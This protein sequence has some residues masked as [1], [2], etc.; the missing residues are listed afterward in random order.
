M[1]LKVLLCLSFAV[2]LSAIN[3]QKLHLNIEHAIKIALENNH[4]LKQIKLDKL[5]AAEQVRQTFGESVLP[6]VEGTATY[7]RAVKRP[8]FFIETP[9]FSGSVPSGTYNNLIAGIQ[10]DQ[11]I[12]TGAMFLAT[13]ISEGYNELAS[14]TEQYSEAELI[15][16]VKDSYYTYL[17]AKE[18][19]K[20][21]EL[22]I[23]RAEENLKNTKNMFSVGRVSEY[24]F[25][26][27]NVQYQNSIPVLS[28]AKNQLQLAANNFKILLGLDLKADME[29]SGELS[30]N[31]RE[32]IPAESGVSKLSNS[33]LLIKRSEGERKLQEL[34][35]SYQYSQHYPELRA[36]G[37]WQMQSQENDDRSFTNWR[38]INSISVGIN[39]RVPIFNGFSVDSRYQQ[40]KIDYDKSVEALSKTKKELM[41]EFENTLASIK[42]E[43]EQISSYQ[44]AVDETEKG[45]QIAQK[46]YSSGLSTQ[47]EITDALVSVTQAKYNYINS[48]YVYNVLHARLDLLLGK[49]FEEILSK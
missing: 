10:I 37:N 16:K 12:A 25:I 41:K 38:Y 29:I 23:K 15:M 26:R 48:V 27:S 1:R 11:P 35:T 40:A 39:L 30:F 46:R 3:A 9:F 33:N 24:D 45:Y 2:G 20:L 5:K 13:K 14:L 21:A 43:E 8:V 4:D 49:S 47:I 22:Q 19:I 44:S 28:E 31:K 6:S 7:S 36:F 32:S 42:K 17:L 34:S 18:Y